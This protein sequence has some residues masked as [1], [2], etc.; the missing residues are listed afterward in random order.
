MVIEGASASRRM[1]AA[2]LSGSNGLLIM[3]QSST[4]EVSDED[5]D[6]GD[7]EVFCLR[8]SKSWALARTLYE[9]DLEWAGTEPPSTSFCFYFYRG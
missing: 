8:F 5:S 2:W 3:A 4:R 1:R 9:N 7:D 6:C